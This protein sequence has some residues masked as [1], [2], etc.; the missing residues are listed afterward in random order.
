MASLI[1]SL[2]IFIL[3]VQQKDEVNVE[4]LDLQGLG[5]VKETFSA[6]GA[7]VG[8]QLEAKADAQ[9]VVR[10]YFGVNPVRI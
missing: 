10:M 3:Q 4:G 2:Y 1:L 6:T 9:A 5:Q 8:A 7:G